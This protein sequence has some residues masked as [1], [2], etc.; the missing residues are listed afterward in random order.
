MLFVGSIAVWWK[1]KV[2]HERERGARQGLLSGADAGGAASGGTMA[3]SI[4]SSVEFASEAGAGPAARSSSSMS[5]NEEEDSRTTP[6]SPKRTIRK[7]TSFIG[8]RGPSQRAACEQR[9]ER[10]QNRECSTGV[11]YLAAVLVVGAVCVVSVGYGGGMFADGWV[12]NVPTTG[13]VPKASYVY[14]FSDVYDANFGRVPM[15]IDFLIDGVDVGDP[16]NGPLILAAANVI[17]VWCSFFDRNLH[18]RIP[19]VPK[20]EASRCVTNSI[21][22]GLS[23]SYR[24]TL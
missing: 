15:P 6:T 21:P 1:L 8:G 13:L 12:S 20:L 23:L 22:L 24:L 9:I 10:L 3:K 5:M 16:K 18:P 14:D 11:S 7:R 4:V 2:E 17:K 19:L